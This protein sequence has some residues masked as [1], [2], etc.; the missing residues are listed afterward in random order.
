MKKIKTFSLLVISLVLFPLITLAQWDPGELIAASDL[1]GENIY[2]I[3]RNLMEWTLGIFGFVGIIGF[4]IAGIMYLTAAGNE[5]QI[6]KAKL[7]MKWS[8]IGVLVG[9]G[10][11]VIIL[12]IDSALYGIGEF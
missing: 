12:A 1:P 4:V 2:F 9:L 8:I 7:A 5:D 10:G 6:N 11:L 3:I